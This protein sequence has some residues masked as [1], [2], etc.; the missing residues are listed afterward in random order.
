MGVEVEIL[1]K[2]ESFVIVV[3]LR[4]AGLERLKV[5]QEG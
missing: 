3:A 2:E 4:K 1:V 5:Q